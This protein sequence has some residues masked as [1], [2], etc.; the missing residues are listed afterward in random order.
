M[1]R[2]PWGE[3][4]RRPWHLAACLVVLFVAS[5]AAARAPQGATQTEQPPVLR[6]G[7]KQVPPFAMKRPDG[8]WTGISIELIRRFSHETGRPYEFVERNLAELLSGLEDGSLDAVAAAVTMTPEREERFDFT[9]PFVVSGLGI[10]VLP[11]DGFALGPVLDRF[12]SGNFVR[13]F[14]LA[15][16]ALSLAS[17]LIWGLEARKNP[18]HFG[19]GWKQGVGSALWW[20]AVTMTTVG[21]GDKAPQTVLGRLVAVIW[22]IAGVVLI[23]ALT[24]AITSALTVSQLSPAIQGPDDL[25]GHTV[26]AVAGSTSEDYL[27]WN[28]LRTLALPSLEACA[29]ALHEGRASAIVYDQ[30][31]LRHYVLSN[32]ERAFHVLPKSF[33][34]WGYGIGVPTGSTLREPLNRFLLRDLSTPGWQAIVDRHLG[35]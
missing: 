15:L 31:L 16:L 1:Q 5:E 22:M 29:D 2:A 14:G 4:F 18:E 23:S 17:V 19:G 33:E 3:S 26:A 12:L 34:P 32:P 20:S 28:G 21:Y 6:V 25:H 8:S 13:T 30:P 27:K 24:A 9:H 10:G 7:T 11:S 35:Q